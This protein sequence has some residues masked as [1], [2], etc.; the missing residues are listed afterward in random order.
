MISIDLFNTNEPKLLHLVKIWNIAESN[1]ILYDKLFVSNPHELADMIGSSTSYTDW[2]MFLT[3]SRVQEYIDKIIYTQAGIIIN[4][5]LQPDIHLTQAESARLN[6]AIKYRDDHKVSFAP[7]VQYI[8]AQVP[9]TY[10][11]SQFLPKVPENEGNI[12]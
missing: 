11:E 6:T 9:L 10:A 12:L 3:D 4:K 1:P 7:P 2:Q 8:Y 5:C